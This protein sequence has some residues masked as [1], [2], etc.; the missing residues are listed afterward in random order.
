[1]NGMYCAV[2]K[3]ICTNQLIKY[4]HI[5]CMTLNIQTFFYFSSHSITDIIKNFFYMEVQ[6]QLE[7]RMK[8]NGKYRQN[9]NISLHSKNSRCSYRC[10][11]FFPREWVNWS[12]IKRS[13]NV[14][15]HNVYMFRCLCI[16]TKQIVL[17]N[18]EFVIYTFW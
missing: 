11:L 7:F 16:N 3:Y 13:G 2:Y 6:L 4:D 10:F 18:G 17:L 5:L 15:F 12:H 9:K 8:M 14:K 1:M